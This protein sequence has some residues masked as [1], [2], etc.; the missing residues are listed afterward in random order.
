V[1]VHEGSEDLLLLGGIHL[2][3]TLRN[4]GVAVVLKLVRL[5][6]EGL[7]GCWLRGLVAGLSRT[8]TLGLRMV[9]VGLDEG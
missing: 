6:G 1:L 2:V 4:N 7:G 9:E 3:E 8:G 5:Y